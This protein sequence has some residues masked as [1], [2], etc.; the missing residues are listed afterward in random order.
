MHARE[1]Q[2][3]LSVKGYVYFSDLVSLDGVKNLLSWAKVQESEDRFD[4]AGIGKGVRKRISEDH[5]RDEILWVK[6][7]TLPPLKEFHD[8]LSYL[9]VEL[10]RGLFLPLKRFEGHVAHYPKDSF[11]VKHIDRHKVQPHRLMTAVFYLS[12]M[13][14][15]E[16]GEL[17]LHL[18]EGKQT[19][20]PQAGSMI[21]F[22]SEIPHEV[23]ITHKDRW[24]L[25]CWFR[26][27]VL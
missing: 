19:I 26:D 25:T 15:G 7:W 24:S 14:P 5:R 13:N 23:Q 11:Y 4:P 1:W 10:R 6:D 27:D 18:P 9:F 16:G 3:E 8:N 12:D 20:H 2:D 21:L 22:Q 17:V